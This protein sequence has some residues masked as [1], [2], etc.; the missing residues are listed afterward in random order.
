MTLTRPPDN[1]S[2]QKVVKNSS[3]DAKFISKNVTK[4]IIE[5][6]VCKR[7]TYMRKIHSNSISI[8]VAFALVI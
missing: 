8:N 4:Y 3:Y 5:S 7:Y 2:I 6:K 1:L